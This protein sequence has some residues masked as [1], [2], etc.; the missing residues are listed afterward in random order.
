MLAAFLGPLRL[1]DVGERDDQAEKRRF[2]L[3]AFLEAVEDF[4]VDD[5]RF[6]FAI[7]LVKTT[8]KAQVDR[9]GYRGQF[10]EFPEQLLRI[11]D[12]CLELV[13]DRCELRDLG[14][15]GADRGEVFLD[16]VLQ[17][18]D[19]VVLQPNDLFARPR[20]TIAGERFL[21]LLLFV[22]L[23]AQLNR[24]RVQLDDVVR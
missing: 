17:S 13:I 14:R 22:K 3:R 23:V 19:P 24:Q 18:G 6:P 10:L 20:R 8:A 21:K 1:V 7:E 15:V 11:C 16:P 9:R 4:L 5:D 2:T 12:A